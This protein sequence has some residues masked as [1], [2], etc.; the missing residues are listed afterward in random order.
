M[1]RHLI[2]KVVL[3]SVLCLTI[4]QT[5][6]AQ[7]P[8]KDDL[9]SRVSTLI[10]ASKTGFVSI[11]GETMDEKQRTYV[12][13]LELSEWTDGFVYPEASEGPYILYVSLGGDDLS[14]TRK[15]YRAWVPRLTA[16]LRGW[17]RTETASAEE[18]KSVFMQTVEGPSVELDYN[19]EPS[20]IGDTKFDLYLTFKSPASVVEKNFC[21]DLS[22]L[23]NASRT[24]FT[25]IVGAVEDQEQGS[26]KSTLKVSA[27]GSGWVY[28]QAADP[29]ALYVILGSNRM[30]EVR[31][32]Y[33]RWV[34]KFA[35]CL[36]GWK[37]KETASAEDVESVFTETGDG[38][39][40]EL[41]YN[42][43]PSTTGS[44]KYDLYLTIQAPRA[45]QKASP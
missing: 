41:E 44:T 37:R 23:I 9:C 25:S 34:S 4:F 24:G 18:V 30:S 12:S 39:S 2:N 5:T 21:G 10:E 22:S 3:L 28:P 42:R 1:T 8:Q 38:P 20:K 29:H 32:M 43:K 15:R 17:K 45:P 14:V 16:C 36:P 6:Q 40:I 35:A 19:I 11:L 33:S 7:E 27:W 31:D 13:K 26:H